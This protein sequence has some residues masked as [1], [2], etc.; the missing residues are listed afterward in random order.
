MAQ[1]TVK[2]IP[3]TTILSAALPAAYPAVPQVTL[4]NAIFFLR[5][6]NET[7]HHIHISFDGV[8]DHEYVLKETVFEIN[9]QTNSLPNNKVSLFAA[10][11]TIFIKGTGGGTSVTISGYYC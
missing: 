9:T 11:D 10:R 3:L 7:N 2:A 8:T 1:N 5:I 6:V 4:P